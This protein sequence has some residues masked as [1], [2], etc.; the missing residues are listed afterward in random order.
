[1]KLL[2]FHALEQEQTKT[3]SKQKT[4][5]AASLLTARALGH[6]KDGSK[7]P[8]TCKAEELQ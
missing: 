4:W 1:M 3:N 6:I 8:S 5:I 2:C 7:R